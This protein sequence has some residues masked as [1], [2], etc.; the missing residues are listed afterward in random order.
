MNWYA[1]YMMVENELLA[2]LETP[3][4]SRPW[5]QD[6]TASYLGSGF[7]QTYGKEQVDAQVQALARCR[8]QRVPV[9]ECAE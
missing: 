8:R 2:T 1:E 3:P 6:F 4:I 5:L 9:V 7:Y